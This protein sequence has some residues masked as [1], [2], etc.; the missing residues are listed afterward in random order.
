MSSSE[1]DPRACFRLCFVNTAGA[2]G[3]GDLGRRALLAQCPSWLLPSLPV[4]EVARGCLIGIITVIRP[5][6]QA[7]VH[8]ILLP[9]TAVAD[10]AIG[11]EKLSDEKQ[12]FPWCSNDRE[13][14]T[15]NWNLS[16]LSFITAH[17]A[18]ASRIKSKII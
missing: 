12:F 10:Y 11:P 5:Q 13:F 7:L 15:D 8:H 6:L 3:L 17:I 14:V 16:G 1:K 2:C 4:G 18:S 9:A